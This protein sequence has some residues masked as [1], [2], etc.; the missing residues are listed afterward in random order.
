MLDRERGEFIREFIWDW[1]NRSFLFNCCDEKKIFCYFVFFLFS[2]LIIDKFKVSPID[3]FYYIE[4]NREKEKV[5]CFYD[6]LE[7]FYPDYKYEF[8]I[9]TIR[10]REDELKA[11]WRL[12][13]D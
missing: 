2:Y 7:S 6:C 5:D 13:F 11:I 4:R 9:N 3:H 8:I 12:D 10:I 1:C